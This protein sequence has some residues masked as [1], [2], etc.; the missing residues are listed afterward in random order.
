M[1]S[2]YF[3]GNVLRLRQKNSQ[4]ELS[5]KIE[6]VYE[7]STLSVVLKVSVLDTPFN[8]SGMVTQ[9]DVI[10]VKLF[11][12][13]FATDL[14][15]QTEHAAVLYDSDVDTAYM[16]S[17]LLHPPREEEDEEEDERDMSESGTDDPCE[18]KDRD[19]D[20]LAEV[21]AERE[22]QADCLRLF[23]TEA[24]VYARLRKMQMCGKIPECLGLVELISDA[25]GL[26]DEASFG[27]ED[28]ERIADYLSVPGMLLSYVDGRPL[29]EIGDF[30]PREKWKQVIV[31]A[32]E[33]I[34]E[35][36][37]QD[38]LNDDVR[39]DN[40]LV[41]TVASRNVPGTV[42]YRPVIL[43][44]ANARLRREDEDKDSWREAKYWADEEGSIGFNMF[45][46]LKLPR[47]DGGP[48]TLSYTGPWS[49]EDRVL[50]IDW[51]ERLRESFERHQTMI[52]EPVRSDS[53][54]VG[55]GDEDDVVLPS[56]AI[57]DG[58]DERALVQKF[59][60]QKL[61]SD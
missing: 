22:L 44:F 6:H 41:R 45:S 48:G 1:D 30:V 7:P 19:D 10:V 35:I 43:D 23:S 57:E 61:G 51:E 5:V 28:R 37:D 42:E 53:G 9:G 50:P 55:D 59:S 18:S 34:N 39:L 21:A 52:D 46:L 56:N 54:S 3:I 47:W 60:E 40:V 11:D 20:M 17:L 13:R 38:V 24:S 31:E 25:R 16:R 4:I 27:K 12:R 33:I 32:C 29:R 36:G 58:C 49:Y 26:Y 8:R 2:P 14:R 15:D